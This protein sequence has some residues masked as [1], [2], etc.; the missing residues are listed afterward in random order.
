MA[1][2]EV[3]R[4]TRVVSLCLDGDLIAE[5]ESLQVEI[6]EAR[7]AQVSDARLNS[8]LPKLEKR[9]A[10]L[11]A[12]QQ[13][14]TVEF[15]LRA[16]PRSVWEELKV[17]HPARDDNELDE[18]YG[19]NTSTLFDEAMATKGTIDEVT[20]GGETVEFSAEDWAGIAEDLTDGQFGDFA[21]ALVEL[22]AGRQR[23]PF[24]SAGYE[25]T[26]DSG[27]NLK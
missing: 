7:R 5:Y 13:E 15:K 1:K 17:K 9:H 27:E 22:N 21:K 19:F 6:T 23:V 25:M 4:P 14:E 26:Q 8:P 18:H 16:L 20:Q 12:K 10:E 11:Y 24:S 3:K 2:L